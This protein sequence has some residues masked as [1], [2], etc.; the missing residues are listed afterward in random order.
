MRD[1]A[2]I[3]VAWTRVR[4]R[5]W[6]F[7]DDIRF[8]IQTPMTFTGGSSQR[9]PRPSAHT[10]RPEQLPTTPYHPREAIVAGPRPLFRA[11]HVEQF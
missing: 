7:C 5:R 6:E 11:D 1:H 9:C 3:E 2:P 10:F 4:P 8:S